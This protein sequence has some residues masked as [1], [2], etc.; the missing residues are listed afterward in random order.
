MADD[1]L[2]EI[3][4]VVADPTAGPTLND[5]LNA[6]AGRLVEALA[7]DEFD[8]GAPPSNEA[9]VSRLDRYATLTSDLARAVALG[10]RGRETPCGRFGPR[11][12]SGL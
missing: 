5:L 11:L 8:P 9:V 3:K 1:F 4:R 12:S 7:G 6:E 10:A 2:T